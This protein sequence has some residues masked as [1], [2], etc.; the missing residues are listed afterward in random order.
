MTGAERGY[1][2]LCSHLGDPERRPLS[3]AQF[4][5]LAQRV[6]SAPRSEEMGELRETDLKALGYSSADCHTILALLAEESR[7]D[8]YLAKASK[9]GCIPLTRASE[10]YPAILRRRLGEDAPGCLW[11]KGDPQLVNTLGVS[12]VGSRDLSPAN[13]QF[14]HAVGA[15]AA[16]QGFALI[17]G[18]A[19]GADRAGQ[20]GAIFAGGQVISVVPDEL[21]RHVPAEQILYLCEDS[22]DLEFSNF[23]ALSRN[24]IIHALGRMTFVAQS[25]LHTG[26]TWDGSA[27]NLRSG[28]SPLFVFDDGSESTAALE[29]MGA[30]LI[31]TE[32][33]EDFSNLPVPFTLL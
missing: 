28:W 10:G 12:L 11:L 4:R 32:D 13:G 21:F 2:L 29:Q 25:S 5:R 14:A 24:R 7:L 20:D 26:G 19:R 15:Q 27:R 17:S 1:L 23:R 9:L 18:N 31:K 8:H 22:F 3:T 33:L 6:R 16:R 30:T